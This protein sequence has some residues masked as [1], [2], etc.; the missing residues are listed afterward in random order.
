MIGLAYSLKVTSKTRSTLPLSTTSIAPPLPVVALL[1][2]SSA[3]PVEVPHISYLH[4]TAREWRISSNAT[5]W[6][7]RME[8]ARRKVAQ[9]AHA[10][11]GPMSR[12]VCHCITVC[13][14]SGV[15]TSYH[16]P[17]IHA[18]CT[19]PLVSTRLCS[20]RC[21]PAATLKWRESLCASSVAGLRPFVP[22][23]T[24]TPT[25]RTRMSDP[26]IK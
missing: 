13:G 22:M 2:H 1:V 20:V 11:A 12:L 4:V 7:M 5:R 6:Q 19:H 16:Y 24:L 23:I 15:T 9:P 26:P 3:K 8:N 21:A 25:P 14:A 10:P 18:P 17:H